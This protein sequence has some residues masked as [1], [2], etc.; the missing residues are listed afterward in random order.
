[1]YDSINTDYGIGTILSNFDSEY[2]NHVIS[3]SI[4]LR[5]RPFNG[6]MPNMVDILNRE[7]AII[8]SKSPDYID[9]V[10]DVRN[11]TMI[12]IINTIC[13]YFN[14]TFAGPIDAMSIDEIYSVARTLY[15][16]FV[17]QFTIHMN[18]FFVSYIIQNADSIYS[19]L[20]RDSS[21]KKPKDSG[22][23][24]QKNYIDPKFVIIHANLNQ[25][26]INMAAYD[27]TLNQLLSYILDPYTAQYISNMV[28]DNN[29]IYKNFYASYI[30]DPKTMAGVLTNIKLQLQSRTFEQIQV[31]TK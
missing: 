7:F 9:Q 26:I 3:D 8:K 25:V 31:E 20:E 15:D 24:A 30:R 10:E 12:N 28:V 29:D 11:E 2:I 21:A 14:L 22:I 16:V 19:Y 13:N 6:P 1:M 5:F 23:Y 17:A 18:N 4:D 27:I